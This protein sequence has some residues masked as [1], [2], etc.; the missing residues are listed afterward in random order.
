MRKTPGLKAIFLVHNETSG[1][2]AIPYVERLA[3]V[4]ADTGAF[5]VV[6]AISSLGGYSIPVDTW[7]V[8][9]CITGSQKCLAAPPGLSLLSLSRRAADFI[10]K[11]PPRVRYFDLGR[12]IEFLAHGETP[13]TPAMSLYY[14]LDEAL[15]W[16]IEEGLDNR[17]KR[18]AVMLASYTPC[19]QRWA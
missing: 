19:S 9:V 4:A 1:G 16:L 15:S 14:A 6:D 2:T 18:H 17:V 11:N 7:G 13:F 3:K 12:Q 8:D 10:R 5:F